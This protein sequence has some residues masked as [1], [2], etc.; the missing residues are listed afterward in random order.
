[1]QGNLAGT[2]RSLGRLDDCLRTQRDVYSGKLKLYGGEHRETL[3]AISNYAYC[4]LNLSRFEAKSLLRR[5]IPVARRV[6]GENHPEALKM[7]GIYAMTLH[8]DPSATLDDLREAATTLEDT[9]RTVRRV[10]GC[11]HPFTVEIGTSLRNSRT[12][13]RA[14]EDGK[15]VKFVKH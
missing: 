12:V 1:M 3:V 5:T 15:R 2:Y 4:L 9:E 7:R 8:E 6:L 11:E 10:F 14:R 13:L